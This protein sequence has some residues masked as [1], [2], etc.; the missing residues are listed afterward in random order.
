MQRST[1]K[2]QVVSRESCR[3]VGDRTEQ[4]GG[5]KDTTKTPIEPTHLETLELT[6]FGPPTREHAEAL[7]RSS[8]YL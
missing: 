3:R 2:H 8:T 6:E 5:V 7:T 1:A 4:V